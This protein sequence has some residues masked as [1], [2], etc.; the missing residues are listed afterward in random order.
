MTAVACASNSRC[1]ISGGGEGQV[2]VWE[3][4]PKKQFMKE[5]LKEHKGAVTCI[6]I[7]NNDQ[8]VRNR[9]SLKYIYEL[10]TY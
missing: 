3:V 10:E 4:T 2:R 5:A 6:K 7:R 8:E 9:A 1:L